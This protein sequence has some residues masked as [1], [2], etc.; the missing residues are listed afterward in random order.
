MRWVR[1]SQLTPN[2]VHGTPYPALGGMGESWVH[3]Y[4]G[5]KSS[6]VVL[7][8]YSTYGIHMSSGEPGPHP[9]QNRVGS[10]EYYVTCTR[11]GMVFFK[12]HECL[13]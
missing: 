9:P 4:T 7:L 10:P 13:W 2:V 6:V 1:I 12:H 3:D 11:G 5:L 8:H